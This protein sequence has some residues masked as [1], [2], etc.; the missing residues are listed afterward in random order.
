MLGENK[1]CWWT[2]NLHKQPQ[3][4]HTGPEVT[5]KAGL[6]RGESKEEK[7]DLS[8]SMVDRHLPQFLVWENLTK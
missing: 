4:T 5:Q 6:L 3:S 8:G 2:G 1:K 7:G